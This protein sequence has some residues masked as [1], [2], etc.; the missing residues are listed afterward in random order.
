MITNIKGGRWFENNWIFIKQT[1]IGITNVR[2]DE[3]RFWSEIEKWHKPLCKRSFSLRQRFQT[4]THNKVIKIELFDASNGNFDTLLCWS[5]VQTWRCL[6]ETLR[7]FP[8]IPQLF[9]P[10]VSNSGS[11]RFRTT[12]QARIFSSRWL[13]RPRS[14]YRMKCDSSSLPVAFDRNRIF[15]HNISKL[16]RRFRMIKNIF[17]C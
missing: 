8:F 10:R 13:Q 11:M 5:S 3:K 6:W 1:Q 12:L 16:Q 4:G 2:S 15:R 9:I 17:C 14:I 7:L